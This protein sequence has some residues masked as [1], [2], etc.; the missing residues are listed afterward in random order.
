MPQASIDPVVMAEA[1]VVTLGSLQAGTKENI[2]LDEAVIKLNVG[3]VPRRPE[4]A[5]R[6]E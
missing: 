1:A 3:R 2:I 6:G 4:D 5:S